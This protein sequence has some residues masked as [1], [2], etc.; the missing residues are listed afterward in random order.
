MKLSDLVHFKNQLDLLS[1]A[2]AK[3]FAEM[4]LNKVTHLMSQYAT[5][6][7][8]EKVLSREIESVHHAFDQF[9][10]TITHLKDQVNKQIA[11]NEKGRFVASYTLYESMMRNETTEYILDRRMILPPEVD[12]ALKS[13]LHLYANWKYPAMIIRPGR[14]D[15]IKDMVSF[16]PLYLIDQ[17]YELL[18]PA[19]KDFPEIY[20]ST[21]STSTST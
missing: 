2:E 6:D 18:E 16:D 10:S 19:I 21:L 20:L 15:F 5:F 1:S 17:N 13:R 14:E 8:A 12:V 4:E 3:R 7:D 11:E 9:E